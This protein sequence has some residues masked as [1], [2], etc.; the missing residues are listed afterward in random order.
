M[1]LSNTTLSKCQTSILLRGLKFTP[2]PQSNSI[3]LT[4]DLKTFARK[5]RLTEYFDDHNVTPIDQKNESLV[6]SKSMFYPPRNRN[7]ELET[8]KSQLITN[9]IKEQNSEVVSINEP[10]D[11]KI[12]PAVGGKVSVNVQQERL[13]N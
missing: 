6:K 12:R 4:C 10:Q 1:N 5:L 7:K 11:L 9:A 8:P 13:V 2:T 3:Q